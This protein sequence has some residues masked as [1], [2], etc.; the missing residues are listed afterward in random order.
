MTQQIWPRP[1]LST[2]Q[3]L[4]LNWAQL[5]VVPE[6]HLGDYVS[7]H[8]QQLPDRVALVYL[9]QT[10]TYS[11]LDIL[12]NRLATGLQQL[13]LHKG[14]VLAIH[15][16]NTPQYVVAFIA[17]SR[18]GLVITSLSALLTPPE[19]IHQLNDAKAR[20]LL[21]FDLVFPTVITAIKDCVASL[22]NVIVTSPASWLPN[23]PALQLPTQLGAANVHDL[24]ALMPSETQVTS[25]P[26][27][28]DAVAFLQ[29]T[30]GTTGRSKGARL[31]LRQIFGNNLQVDVFNQYRLGQEVIAS[32]FPLFHIGGSAIMHNALRVAA[33]LI[34]TP[35]PRQVDQFTHAMRM[36]PPT[37]IAN[38]P[39]LFQMLLAHAPFTELDF[40]NLRLAISGAA[41]FT[42]TEIERLSSIIGPG[43]V[44]EVYG[45]TETSPVQTCNP[46][47]AFK[48]GSV[49]IPVLGTDLRI[50]DIDQACDMPLGEP[51]E[52]IVSG[53]QVMLGYLS[54]ADQSGGLI[55]L[56]EST[57]MFTGDIGWLDDEGYLHLCD[58]SKDML[59]VGGYKVFSVEVEAVVQSLKW[60][61]M[62][63]LVGRPDHDRP[64]NDVGRLYVQLAPNADID[65]ASARTELLALCRQ[66][67]APYKVPREIVFVAAIPLTSVG[68]IDKKVLRAQAAA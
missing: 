24:T 46:P 14:D 1:W 41:P 4:G 36:H 12:A 39:A 48:L 3:S 5:P 49:G 68:K 29:Y 18:L 45:M 51:G 67:L 47:A 10:F 9:G 32:A 64:G 50:W 21:T 43:K 19:L 30:G 44:C 60:V 54:S 61:A 38:V 11:A 22:H 52:I 57:W 34:I 63:A 31:N 27:D 23:A 58:R 65:E 13:G 26:A 15:L 42:A 33:T 37:V 35:D 28:L 40:S 59:I 25:V 6:Q 62:S 17:A 56:D 7:S 53:P 66:H 2:Y 20:A 8:A 16:P 55:E